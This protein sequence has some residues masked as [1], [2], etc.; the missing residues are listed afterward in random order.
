ML[1]MTRLTL[2]TIFGLV[3]AAFSATELQAAQVLFTPQVTLG[4]QY[5]DNIFLTPSNEQ[6]DFITSVGLGFTGQM[7]W[8]TAGLQLIYNPS[9]NFYADH[10]DVDYWRHPAHLHAWKDFT[11]EI[12]LDVNDDYLET[13]NPQDNTAQFAA[14]NPLQGPAIPTDLLR[15]G[16]RKYR[17]NTADARLTHQ[18]GLRDQY[19]IGVQSYIL[20]NIQTPINA[21]ANDYTIWQPTAGLD[22][23]FGPLWGLETRLYYANEDYTSNLDQKKYNG[24]LKL[25][26]QITRTF[27]G[28]VQYRQ[29]ALYYD[30]P[31]FNDYQIYSPSAGVQYQFEQNAYISIGGGY[32]IQNIKNGDNRKSWLATSE[33]YK[34]WAFRSGYV[35]LTGGSGYDIRDTGTQILGLDIYYTGRL[36]FNYNLTQRLAAVAYGAYRYDN[37]PNQ[38]PKRI[39]RVASAGAGLNYQILRWMSASLNYDFRKYISDIKTLEYKENRVTLLITMA[40]SVPYR[41]K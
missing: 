19:F 20:R 26:R 36:D 12:R 30:K 31:T 39:D 37:F 18:F 7:L 15:R 3:I 6:H 11:R 17:Q 5:S 14:G 40:P 24:T 28:F 41:W 9:Y 2:M 38:V 16:I 21:Q 33:I 4:E 29:T 27:S 13:A 10:S 25:L 23:W 22:Y 8:Q 34:R 35:D 1:K 32:Y